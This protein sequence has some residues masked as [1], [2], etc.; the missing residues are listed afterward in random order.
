MEWLHAHAQE[1]GWLLIGGTLLLSLAVW[2]LGRRSPGGAETL[3]GD[4]LHAAAPPL[5]FALWYY[6]AFFVTPYILA[7]IHPGWVDGFDAHRGR[8]WHLGVVLGVTWFLYRM[9]RVIGDFLSRRAE[10]TAG[11][12]DDYLFRVAASALRTLIPLL[13]LTALLRLFQLPPEAWHVLETVLAALFIGAGAAILYRA[14]LDGEATILSRIDVQAADVYHVR[15]VQT[16][17]RI[18]RKFAVVFLFLVALAGVL[19]LLPGV[20]ALGTSILA[21][22]GVAGIVLG[23]AA[24]RTLGNFF[25]GLQIALTQPIR[26][27]DQVVVQGE[28]GNIEEIALTY[29][30]LRTWDGRRLILPITQFLEQPFQNWTRPASAMITTVKLRVDFSL[31]L[32][33]V[34]DEMKKWIEAS[35]LWDKKVYAFQVTDADGASMEIRIIAGVPG[36]GPSFD[37]QCGIR[38]KLITFL[39]QNYAHCLPRSRQETIWSEL[40]PPMQPPK[41]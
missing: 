19:L 15:A 40:N 25:A 21:S 29:V 3:R 38:E 26:L 14:I 30:V 32:E 28:S 23:I 2:M 16:R 6:A 8:F 1:V 34:R 17:V 37:L 24:Q 36:P 11:A 27:G 10:R 7:F 33:P 31:P 35:P 41:T 5:Q 22:A 39:Q 18:L 12:L 13:G 9:V 20:R 4:L